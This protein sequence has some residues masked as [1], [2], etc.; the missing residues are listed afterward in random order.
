MATHFETTEVPEWV[1]RLQEKGY[2]IRPATRSTGVPPAENRRP[3][4]PLVA[5]WRRTIRRLTRNAPL[6]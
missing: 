1:R 6:P 2:R 4:P 5:L 3:A